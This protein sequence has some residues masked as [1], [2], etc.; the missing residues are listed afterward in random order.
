MGELKLLFQIPT[1]I[2]LCLELLMDMLFSP[3]GCS[4]FT[5]MEPCRISPPLCCLV[6]MRICFIALLFMTFSLDFKLT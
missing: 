2:S 6:L 5:H 4:F 3:V 1:I